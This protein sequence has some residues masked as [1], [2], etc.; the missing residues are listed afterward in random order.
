MAESKKTTS[1]VVLRKL[2]SAEDAHIEGDVVGDWNA[3]GQADGANDLAAIKAV[4]ADLGDDGYG[5]FVAVPARSF[6]PHTRGRK[7]VERDTWE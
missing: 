6:K 4:T 2:I 5:T 1:Y 7:V 3:V